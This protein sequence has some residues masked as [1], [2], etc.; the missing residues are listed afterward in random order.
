MKCVLLEKVIFEALVGYLD[1][2]I[3]WYF[4]DEGDYIEGNQ[5]LVVI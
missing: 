3:C 5:G 2:K 1:G 4:V